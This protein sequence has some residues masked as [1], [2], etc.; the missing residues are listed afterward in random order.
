MFSK[1]LEDLIQ[2]TLEDGI[3]EEN[4]KAALVKRATAEGVDIAELEIYINSILQRRQRKL[5]KEADARREKREQERKEALGR[6]CPNCGK[7]IPP[8]TLKCEC[9]YEVPTEKNTSS[10]ATLL[11][12]K[13]D[14][15]NSKY[16]RNMS[17]DDGF[18]AGIW[19]RRQR[20]D[21]KTK[22]I[23]DAITFCPVPN[24]K[25]DIIEFLSLSCVNARYKGG[26][27]GTFLNRLII[28]LG[29]CFVVALIV[30]ISGGFDGNAVSDSFSFFV[31]FGI[32]ATVFSYIFNPEVIFWNKRAD[33]WRAKFDQI[34]MKGRSMHGD[35]EFQKQL[36]YFQ[37]KIKE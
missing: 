37:K 36:D 8:M 35:T 30:M 26:F 20:E 4:E 5:N 11:F 32:I 16:S 14:E 12:N 6:I 7:Q 3:L 2:A 34:I 13:I 29:V 25:E 1:E 18:F 22:E 10:S 28:L 23:I 19:A 33:A 31:V 21:A 9:G 17:Y 27:F 15:I 24:T